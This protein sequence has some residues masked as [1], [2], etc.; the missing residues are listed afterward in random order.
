MIEFEL[1]KLICYV[2]YLCLLVYLAIDC[3]RAFAEKRLEFLEMA[4]IIASIPI[5][6]F[7]GWLGLGWVFSPIVEYLILHGVFYV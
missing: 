3:Q 1:V 5:I 6:G 7:F 4:F 2:L